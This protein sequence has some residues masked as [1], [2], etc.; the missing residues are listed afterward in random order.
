M[1]GALKL[2]LGVLS[3]QLFSELLCVFD[4][5]AVG[6][7]VEVGVDGA[8]F[9]GLVFEPV[10]PILQ[11]RLGV[12]AGISAGRTVETNVDDLAGDGA[13]RFLAGH[14]V[15][16]EAHAGFFEQL[17]GLIDVPAFVPEF[18]DGRLIFGQHLDKTL[19]QVEVFVQAGRQLIENRAE[20]V[21]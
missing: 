1:C 6:V 8:G 10:G 16:T 3:V 4:G 9:L 2:C 19:E 7:V 20:R 18:E 21:L 17:E 13:G 14:V 15:D 11:C 5:V 12:V